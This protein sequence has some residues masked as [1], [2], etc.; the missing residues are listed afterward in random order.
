MKSSSQSLAFGLPGAGHI[1]WID[2]AYPS[3]STSLNEVHPSYPKPCQ[4]DNAQAWHP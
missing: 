4:D 3:Q 1:S 2:E